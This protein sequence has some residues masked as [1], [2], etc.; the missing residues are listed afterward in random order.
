M[1]I[2]D[3]ELP[4]NISE[5]SN[6]PKAPLGSPELTELNPNM[7]GFEN[8]GQ[9]PAM[10]GLGLEELSTVRANNT[11][12]FDSPFQLVTRKE[13]VDNK[14]YAMYER[15]VDLENI[16]GQKQSAWS[17]WGNSAAKFTATAVG[18]F[19]QGFMTIPDT[20]NGIKNVGKGNYQEAVKNLAGD[21]DGIEG[22]VDNWLKNL[23]DVFPNYYTRYEREHP[24]RAAIPFTQGS[25]NFWGDKVLKNLGFTVGAI[26]SAVAQSAI[27]GAIT[28]GTGLAPIMAA[29][30][31]KAALYLNKIFTGAKD[32]EKVLKI[33]TQVG[34]AAEA[35]LSVKKLA[36]V[37]A[38]IKVLNSAQYMMNIYGSA[39][40]EA[41][42][43]ARDGYRQVKEDL[44]NQY[45]LE[46]LGADVTPEALQE[47]DD[48]ATDAMN[49]RFGINMALL[50]VSN[51]VQF[52]SLFKSFSS[53]SS[54]A[55]RGGLRQKI[56]K[57]GRVGLVEG[58]LD[59]F[60][61]KT[62]ATFAGRAW[63]SVKPKL[64]D[65]FSE[66]VYEEG[67]QFAAER[68]TYDYYTRKYKNPKDPN[69]VNNWNDLNETISSTGYGLMEQFG[70]SAGIENMFLGAITAMITGGVTGKIDSMKGRGKD[71]RLTASINSLN[72]YGLTGVLS[73]KYTDTLNAIRIS[74]EM[75]EAAATGNVF[76]YKNL[77]DDMFFNFV[78]S[79]VPSGLHDV[80]IEQL[81]ML[82]DLQKEDFEKTF[83]MDFNQSSRDTVDTYVDN[84][85]KKADDI[86]KTV[87]VLDD[88][89]KNPFKNAVEPKTP[90]DQVE[91]LNYDTF[92]LWKTDLAKYA[93]TSPAMNDRLDSI[94]NQLIKINPLLNN[95]V[96][97]SITDRDSL[98]NLKE[99]YNT[100]AQQ[101]EDAIATALTKKD[102]TAAKNNVDKLRS[103][104]N[105]I[106][107]MLKN[108]FDLKTVHVLLNLEMNNQDPSQKDIV[109]IEY[110]EKLI[111][112]GVDI[113]KN[114]VL[115]KRAKQEYENLASKKGFI[116]Y[117]EQAE[118]IAKNETPEVV[119]PGETPTEPAVPVFDI[120]D[121]EGNKLTVKPERTYKSPKARKT[122]VKK[123]AN[124]KFTVETP[125]GELNFDNKDD[126]QE[127]AD[128]VNTK[129]G[130]SQNVTIKSLND[131]GTVTIEDED[132]LVK[133]V[134]L[135]QL[136]GYT[137][138][139]TD[140]ELLGNVKDSIDADQKTIENESG[141]LGTP[142][143]LTLDEKDKIEKNLSG[144]SIKK[145][146]KLK[147]ALEIFRSTTSLAESN[148]D[149][150]N[151][152]HIIR[153][154]V[155]LNNAPTFKNR[156]R[157]RAILVTSANEDF[158]N[159]TGFTKLCYREG[160]ITGAADVKTGLMSQVI[161][162]ED[163]DNASIYYFVDQRGNR[164]QENR[165]DVRLGEAVDLSKIILMNM[166][167]AEA[168]YK[169]NDPDTGKPAKRWREE[170][171]AEFMKQLAEYTAYR[172]QVI[173]DPKLYEIFKFKISRG[174]SLVKRDIVSGKQIDERNPVGASEVPDISPGTLVPENEI[175][176]T[177][178]LIEIPDTGYVHHQEQDLKFVKGVPMLHYGATLEFLN[179]RVFNA[180]EANSIYYTI[181][182]LAEDLLKQ[183]KAGNKKVEINPV[184][185]KYLQHVLYWKYNKNKLNS[186]KNQIFI[187]T[188]NKDN[189][190]ITL[191]QNSY[192]V[193]DIASKGKEIV[194][195]L[196]S[197]YNNVNNKSVAKEALN[198]P[199]VELRFEK[200]ADSKYG[201]VPHTWEN[202]QTALL[203]QYDD[204]GKTKRPV[205][206]IPLTT[207]VQI[208][209]AAVPYSFAQRYI[210]LSGMEFPAV[211]QTKPETVVVP[212]QDPSGKPSEYDLEGKKDNKITLK[213]LG[214]VT[215]R[216]NIV[217]KQLTVLPYSSEIIKAYSLK[218]KG[219][220]TDAVVNTVVPL[221]KNNTKIEIDE[222]KLSDD[223]YRE[224]LVLE[225]ASSM[226]I[227]TL[228][229]T[230]ISEGK[231]NAP[232][233]VEEEE[234]VIEEVKLE[235]KPVKGTIVVN[236]KVISIVGIPG[237]IDFTGNEK[238]TD[239]NT[240]MPE[241]TPLIKNWNAEFVN[242]NLVNYN[243]QFIFNK[244]GRVFVLA[245]VG[246]FII[247]YY[248]SSKGT[249]G[250][251]IDWH[252][253]FGID[254][255]EDWIIKGSV[256]TQ[257][258]VV[259]D[260]WLIDRFPKSIAELEKVKKEIRTKLPLTEEQKNTV[261]E[262]LNR[263]NLG[264]TKYTK[265]IDSIYKGLDVVKDRHPDYIEVNENYN[266]LLNTTLAAI[267]L[268]K[269]GEK[270]ESIPPPSV[271]NKPEDDKVDFKPLN[272]NPND[273][274]RVGVDE[275]NKLKMT[276]EEIELFKD[277]T[278]E[279]IPN[280]PY[281]V[282]EN[283]VDTY[284]NEKAYGVFENGT[285]KFY[286][287]G[288]R[289]T[290]YH[291]AGEAIWNAL[292]T[293]EERL[294]ILTQ[295]RASGKTFIDRES[296]KTLDY[297]TAQDSQIKERIMDDLAE[298]QLGRLPA[299]S[300]GEA[301]LR[302]F[303]RIMEWFKAFG[304][305]PSLKTELFKAIN[306]G[307]FKKATISKEAKK[308]A[309]QYS[310]VAGLTV[311]Q[312]SNFVQDMTI[313]II[314]IIFTTDKKGLYNLQTATGKDIYNALKA[315]YNQP[316]NMKYEVLGEK[317]FNDLFKRTSEFLHTLGINL[318]EDTLVDINDATTNNRAYAA[319]AFSTDWKKT[320]SFVIKFILAT[321]PVVTTNKKLNSL[322]LPAMFQDDE[323]QTLALNN[324]SKMFATIMD[325]L[326]NT[327]N[328][329]EVV[330]KLVKLSKE[331]PNFARLFT[332]LNGTYKD[333]TYASG[334]G[335]IDFT[336]YKKDDW[337]LFI[338]MYQTF[339]K[340]KPEAYIQYINGG[341][342]YTGP[343]NQF[344][345]S[346]IVEGDWI[347]NMKTLSMDKSSIIA[348]NPDTKTYKV[349]DI[350][351]KFPIKTPQD[352][353]N[354]LEALGID[355]DIKN[356][357]KLD[358]DDKE[359]FSKAVVAIREYITKLPD[360]EDREKGL[361][362]GTITNISGQIL[363]INNR[364]A[365][366]ANLYVKVTNPVQDN[367]HP[368]IK[369]TLSQ[370]YADNN[371]ASVFENEFNEAKNVAEIKLSR[372]E[373]NDVFSTN[374]LTLKEGGLFINENGER[375]R[376]IKVSY[377]EGISNID[378][379][380]DYSTTDLSEGDRYTQEI[381]Q[382]LH[383]NYYILVPAD[384][385]TEWMINLGNNVVFEDVQ[386]G[387]YLNKIHKIFY[388]Y[389]MDEIDLALD[390]K[391]RA[392]L[393]NLGNRG[394]QLRF[395]KEMLDE[396]IVNH[397][398]KM[399]EDGSTKTEILSYIDANIDKINTSIEKLINEF[400]AS[401]KQQLLDSTQITYDKR[402]GLYNY[403]NLDNTFADESRT[404]S[405][406]KNRL[407]DKNLNDILTF[408]NVNYLI[409][410]IEM[411]KVLFGD[412]YQFADKNGNLDE[413]KRIK[414]FLSPRRV[415]LST[416]E[417]NADFNRE[418]NVADKAGEIALNP[419]DYG[420]HEHKQYANTITFNDI[421]LLTEL[422]NVE[423][424][425][426]KKAFD[427]SDGASVIMDG[428]YRE[429][430]LKNAQ[431]GD[432]A[433]AWH[434]WQMAYTRQ[435][436]PGYEYTNEVLRAHDQALVKT[437]EP[438]FT[439][440]I[441]KPI[442]SGYKYNKN[443]IDLVLDKFSQMPLYYKAI[444]NTNLAK[445]YI[446]MFNAKV[447]YAVFESARKVGAEKMYNLYNTDAT[448]NEEPFTEFI[449]V[450]WKAYGIQVENSYEHPHEQTRGSQITK[451]CTMDMFENGEP[452]GNSPEEKD[453]VRAEYNRNVDLLNKIHHNAY[454][455]LLKK[456]GIVDTGLGYKFN[457]KTLVDTLRKEL[458]RREMSTN[459]LDSLE[460]DENDQ[461]KYPFESS[462]MYM[463]IKDIV[464]SM[465]NNSLISVKTSGGPKVQ[466]PV[467]LW[468][469]GTKGRGLVL[470]EVAED[471]KITYTKI[472]KERFDGLNDLQK[473]NVTL[474]S[475][476]LQFYVDEEGQR[477][478][479]VM[480]P[481]W[482]REKLDKQKF[483]T[484]QSI[485]DYLNKTDEGKEILRGI[486][487]RIPTQSMSSIE[488]IEVAGF[489]P[490][491][492][493]DTVIVPSE[494]TAKSGS[495]FDIDKLNTYLK[496]VY[497]DANG[498]IRL[499]K[500]FDSEGT[501][502]AFYDSIY[503]TRYS[504]KIDKLEK[505]VNFKDKLLDVLSKLETL[506]GMTAESV[507]S[508]LK[509]S[510]YKF[511][512][513]NLD[514]V[515]EIF[516]QALEDGI[517]ASE[518]INEEARE[519]EAKGVKFTVKLL[520]AKLRATF[521]D[522]KYKQSLENSYYDSIE[523]LLTMKSNFKQLTHP[524]DDG[525]LARVA[526]RLDELRGVPK[527]SSIKNRLIQRTYLTSLRH[528]F[529]I[530]KRWV[531]I[532]AVNITG[533]SV[534]Q[535]SKS[536]I[537][538]SVALSATDRRILGD[539]NM[540]ISHNT[541]MIDGK[542]RISLSGVMTKDGK[543]YIS[544]RLSGYGTA[545]VDVAKDPYIMKII[546][547][548][549]A[550]GTFMFLERVGAGN[551]GVVFLNQPIIREYLKYLDSNNIN[552]L[553]SY[554]NKK[555]ILN[556]FASSKVDI[557]DAKISTVDF[558]KNIS[559]YYKDGKFNSKA[560]NSKDNAVQQ[561]I[562]NEFL[563][564]AKMADYSFKMT[565][566][567][568]YDTAKF[569]TSDTHSR[570][571]TKTEIA[572]SRNIIS[573]VN[574]ILN[575]TFIGEQKDLLDKML[576]MLGE[577]FK[578]EQND[579]KAITSGVMKPYEEREFMSQDNFDMI[580]GKMNASFLDYVIQIKSPNLTL[581][582]RDLFTGPNSVANQ[583]IEAKKNYPELSILANLTTSSAA[584]VD[585]PRL[586]KFKVKPKAA[587]DEDL[588]IDGMRE[589][590]ETIPGLFNDLVQVAL[591]QGS[592]NSSMSFKNVI[593]IEDYAAKIKPIIDTLR[594]TIDIQNFDKGW[595]ERNKWKDEVL[596]PTY[597]PEFVP[598]VE[599]LEG[600]DIN[601][602]EPPLIG[603]DRFGVEI[604]QYS[605]GIF[606]STNA[607]QRNV[608]VIDP[609]SSPAQ[610]QSDFIK[611]PRVIKVKNGESIDITTGRTVT[612]SMRMDRRKA[613][614][615]SLDSVYGYQKVKS[616]GV[617]VTDKDGNYVYKRIN[618]YG[619]GQYIAE[620]YSDFKPSALDNGA[621]KVAQETNND[622]IIAYFELAEGEYSDRGSIKLMPE[623]IEQIKAGTKTMTSRTEKEK[624]K[625]GLYTLSDGTIVE[626]TPIGKYNVQRTGDVVEIINEDDSTQLD[627]DKF[628]RAEGYKDW[629]NFAKTSF[630]S[631][632]FIDGT[633]SRYLYKIV[634][635]E[636]TTLTEEQSLPLE[637]NALSQQ[638]RDMQDLENQMSETQ[639]E[640]IVLTNLPKI[641]PDSAKRETGA[642]TGINKDISLSLLSNTGLSVDD[643][644]HA[645]WE[646]HFGIDSNITTSEIRNVIIDILNAGSKA[647]YE[648]QLGGS[649]RIQRL[650]SELQSKQEQ[651]ENLTRAKDEV[652][653]I[654]HMH[655]TVRPDGKMF[656]DNGNELTNQTIKNKVNV[657]Q[658]IV[659]GTLR[660]S[661]YNGSVYFVLSD[662]RVV[663]S[664]GN[665]FGKESIKDP[666]IK[667][668]VLARAVLYKSK[669]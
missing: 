649:E 246:G 161:L 63:D 528:S 425:T 202:Y 56:E 443:K 481:F 394:K 458:L 549:L 262:Q 422:Y 89:F 77:K 653:D 630:L 525:G 139:Q 272:K 522:T 165:K 287:R 510:E 266:Y 402:K 83:G 67:G 632:S 660:S 197:T 610:A 513:E 263:N 324:F 360:K 276:D 607:V 512:M 365:A 9:T 578:L 121:K 529:L 396:N 7:G 509:P 313:Q 430:K 466:A 541:I 376:K 561:K 268:D 503:T 644:T 290:E 250:K 375:Y 638:I 249:S 432:K 1:P 392:K 104:A 470:K 540:A 374:S 461:L 278:A 330:N 243:G 217:D 556:K 334:K 76:K 71:A 222:S 517:S 611:I 602:L 377:I 16:Y 618:L 370:N 96:V 408:T 70:T 447:D 616:N 239:F 486:G 343:A 329:D 584:N 286:K 33:G 310:K 154:R 604:H 314:Q 357:T 491:F 472:S 279:V 652:I 467:T 118:E 557:R 225:L 667:A 452:I 412:P 322:G 274:R 66:G 380:K 25:A 281:E 598:A 106:D 240:M 346:K 563:K 198:T 410:N 463:K 26:G 554:K 24:F 271:E 305:N 21:P 476:T 388:G 497:L 284:D 629:N 539:Y 601:D 245:K 193:A 162:E 555:V 389:L 23:E 669:C 300:I 326:S 589:L 628:A 164:I 592:Y 170:E 460:L 451:M 546:S 52:D 61:K 103:A 419:D 295:E 483:P 248:F 251:A 575:S 204:D 462:P 282:L 416:P 231:I 98:E 363:G 226:I 386:S 172:E 640:K 194:E 533:H 439:I 215:F 475:D 612:S 647:N 411:H 590:K 6:L 454:N 518:L 366:L 309:P 384:G 270:K 166:H 137:L 658:E 143:A 159:L 94:N 258:N 128:E 498:D 665:N 344:T 530:A 311:K 332:R 668:K 211:V 364:M 405:I 441:M 353:L 294:A 415:T 331:D 112:Y 97:A 341:K 317:R 633:A 80:T 20:I 72:Q 37:A 520:D 17:Q 129:G 220:P 444:E 406:N 417:M 362:K 599:P 135:D 643:A 655:I 146:E 156:S 3:N 177:P 538:P 101:Q 44:L 484:D 181:K 397:I 456:L 22:T 535:K 624:L 369:G 213:G 666:V 147:N 288:L 567:T 545:F 244:A 506:P 552:S 445:L 62:A 43:E 400:T 455:T 657:R 111:D 427:E 424:K 228:I 29:K 10:T 531:G 47:I 449:Q 548:N 505:V 192:K 120:E 499:V 493:G 65:L 273:F 51:A 336:D 435:H 471:G 173:K 457:A 580:A 232:K 100:R 153:A 403:A 174:V 431:W 619:D 527:D 189:I 508:L 383:G 254:S 636:E 113:N 385:A 199:Y 169:Y 588:A 256:D 34:A 238:N 277:W 492:M 45:K 320:S 414:S 613:G 138:N 516:M 582:I 203:S 354:F 133:V 349:K 661:V 73:Q 115:Q 521:V 390:Y 85:I 119:K 40:T 90:E 328:V 235:N 495:D 409:N 308:L 46:N 12:T 15:G 316:N 337:R 477:R 171:E 219:K 318:N 312:A 99:A 109:P 526:E 205:S 586:I 53:A 35:A 339:T 259:Y 371:V 196:K 4:V 132:G 55:I 183:S 651:L 148:P 423:K 54:G 593:P 19:G 105:R 373:L 208:P 511:Y 623:S 230:L 127:A 453:A 218:D 125:Q 566:A 2:L 615:F 436:V 145:E 398:H 627:P 368:N 543:D 180:N 224:Q 124:D 645:I 574:D 559:K 253:V 315:K 536:Y 551:E 459:A 496:S 158:L 648:S 64:P 175:S 14:R 227:G 188:E 595:F 504:D 568:N 42:V 39:R 190:V 68:G 468:E 321:L 285:I 160:D 605:S 237:E 79:R 116:K 597:T 182:A 429:V 144:T 87:D 78:M 558:G 41:G 401:T 418:Y 469:D 523:K 292:L 347:E 635:F 393:V 167:T 351:D 579:F 151:V 637:I 502:R 544:N 210:V 542:P 617:T 359:R 293:P 5:Q 155:F 433:E 564:Y 591:I 130:I 488:V 303:K 446:K 184:Y 168:Y 223:A 229:P 31:G 585:A 639:L 553:F 379:N 296:G 36:E 464:Y 550:I 485:L 107:L 236:G 207:S 122:K 74:K 69:N 291:E 221:L 242:K 18:I 565:Q 264:K 131:D 482:F 38:G 501:T 560:G 420:Y 407:S 186:S 176:S 201:L 656:Y 13:L 30:V 606:L 480:L 391:G 448:F 333:G 342:I 428:A 378:N 507:K 93:S 195:Q 478:C 28:G 356:Y 150:R 304:R 123:E 659:A 437:P 487:F 654:D 179:N 280:L 283:M 614:D 519:A 57:A 301:V 442:V 587:Y 372:P 140:N 494:I 489:L 421:K 149:A 319:E 247:P 583:L 134:P 532:A 650:K 58:S 581:Q 307:R 465:V 114:L 136:K 209:T 117:V 141:T 50:T 440:E 600:E 404:N 350:R 299:K 163:P 187:N 86:K 569:K 261:A 84:L 185:S 537:D 352:K 340:Q 289:G 474:T 514:V 81:K 178:G 381:N 413:T 572:Q 576:S 348:Y 515:E 142:P 625:E 524:V 570:K 642:K 60:E 233:T 571:T 48:Y 59:V 92:N 234:E 8:F 626:V 479:Q 609:Y 252:Y 534:S 91:K 302:F 75:D 325:A 108:G 157:L 95:E 641:T 126:A 269:Q 212:P 298:Y 500:Y 11:A 662:N 327:T 620:Y 323:T 664:Y 490:K 596:F 102:K 214:E 438:S 206:D 387:E 426:V 110:V 257:G 594:A 562:L 216:A 297:A 361:E 335:S 265:T 88:T 631:L 450:P 399:I 608:V 603:E 395:F 338:N 32:L 473:K 255:E 241:I 49:T 577:I 382:N 355:F 275:E 621:V 634:P 267:G 306:A 27:I 345:A 434:Q 573:S 646:N 82:K 358:D 663:V 367:T 152:P 260:K 191:G 200:I 622:D 547:S